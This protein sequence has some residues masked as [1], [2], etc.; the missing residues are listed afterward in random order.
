MGD[1]TPY[2][3]TFD[4]GISTSRAIMNYGRGAVAG[5]IAGLY[6]GLTEIPVEWIELFP[7]K[8]WIIELAK[9]MKRD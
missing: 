7:K 9:K 2:G 4:C 3:N 5:G 8:E 1:Y 6:Y